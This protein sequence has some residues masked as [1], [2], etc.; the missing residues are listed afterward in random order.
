MK[1]MAWE[2]LYLLPRD[3]ESTKDLLAERGCGT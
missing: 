1:E 3:D 2:A